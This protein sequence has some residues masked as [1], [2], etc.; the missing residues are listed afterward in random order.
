MAE[1]SNANFLSGD[2]VFT[3]FAFPRLQSIDTANPVLENNRHYYTK[4]NDGNGDFGYK[5]VAEGTFTE[6]LLQLSW[7]DK[8]FVLDNFVYHDYASRLLP[9]AVG[10][11][12]GLIDYFFR[13]IID[14]V[15]EGTDL[16]P[17][18]NPP[19]T[20]TVSELVNSTPDEE[21]ATG[22]MVLVLTY[23]GQ[24]LTSESFPPI[25]VSE[26]VS[27]TITRFP[28]AVTFSFSSL[29]FP[30]TFSGHSHYKANLVYRGPLGGEDEAVIVNGPCGFGGPGSGGFTFIHGRFIEGPDAVWVVGG[31]TS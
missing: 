5:L 22:T 17:L 24:D 30:A 26:P 28:Q 11:S 3:D 29:P 4:K 21:T 27:V 25:L 20:L 7:G 31:C 2:T 18:A 13:G 10:Y 19:T 12:A 23:S 6:R 1:Y 9:R 16:F 8:G 14:S 15:P